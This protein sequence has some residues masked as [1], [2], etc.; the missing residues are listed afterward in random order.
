M[1]SFQFSRLFRIWV[2]V[3][4]MTGWPFYANSRPVVFGYFGWW[5]DQDETLRALSSVDRIKYMEWKLGADGSIANKNGWPD[6]VGKVKKR[7][8]ELGIPIDITLTLFSISDFNAL[9]GSELRVKRLTAALV[10]ELEADPAIRGLHLDVEIFSAVHPAAQLRYRAFVANLSRIAKEMPIVRSTSIF[11]NHGAEKYLY[12]AE[13]LLHVDHVV[14]QGYD[15]H[16]TESALVGPVSPLTGS[17]AMTWEKMLAIA[18]ELKLFGPRILMGF[19]AYGYEWTVKPCNP[20]GQS[21]APGKT[22]TFAR[23]P[24]HTVPSIVDRVLEY[25][26]QY[27]PTTGSAHYQFN[28]PDGSCQVGWFEDWWTLQRKTDW[29]L[30]EQLAGIA[31]FPLGYDGGDLVGMTARRFRAIPE[32]SPEPIQLQAQ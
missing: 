4:L 18:R 22:T 2:I 21:L 10:A 3:L 29:I 9:F 8:A 6:V 32:K 20:R 7:A 19:P 30:K 14:L 13:T 23:T 27:D 28:N 12:D 5:I 17:D 16:S 31:F 25:G 11:L 1:I 15:S 24:S 26:A